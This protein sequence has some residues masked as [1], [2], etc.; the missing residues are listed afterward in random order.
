FRME[1]LDDV[2]VGAGF[3]PLDLVL[4]TAAG[5][6]DQDRI[7]QPGFAH[8]RDDVEPGRARQAEIDDGNVDRVFGGVEQPFFAFAGAVN[9]KAVVAQLFADLFPQVDVVLDYQRTHTPF[10]TWCWKTG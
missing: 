7:V 1:R 10:L 3:Q 9:G 6:Q 5:R 8:I 2:V 4:P